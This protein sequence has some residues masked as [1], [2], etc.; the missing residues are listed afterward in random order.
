M[1]I[2]LA[3]D[4][5]NIVRIAQL[6]LERMGGHQVDTAIDGGEALTKAL[7]GDYDLLLLD[8]MMPVYLGVEVCR[9][10]RS[11]KEG[12]KARVIFLSAKSLEADIKEFLELGDGLYSK[13]F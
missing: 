12:P 2:L 11:Y 6:T 3:E 5:P 7:A 9:L 13:T 8:G 10:Y 1:K 4:D